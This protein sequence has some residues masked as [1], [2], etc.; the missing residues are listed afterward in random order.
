MKMKRLFSML[1]STAVATSVLPT[2]AFAAQEITVVDTQ[3]AET[4]ATKSGACGD[5]LI[6]VLDDNGNLIIS[7]SGDM[8]DSYTYWFDYND[9]NVWTDYKNSIKT[10]KI[11][12]GVTSIG[13]SSFQFCK[14]LTSISIPSS[15]TSIGKDRY[16]PFISCSSLAN[17][18]VDSNNANYSSQDGVLFDKDKTTLIKCP[19]G[20]RRTAYTIPNS[21]T[22]LR[23]NAFVGCTRLTTVSIPNSVTYIGNSAFQTCSNLVSVSIPSSVT[24][25]GD[26]AFYEC[27]NLTDVFYSGTENEWKKVTIY[28]YNDELINATVHYHTHSYDRGAITTAATCTKAG[29]KTFTCSEC[30]E[31]KRESIPAIGHTKVID[32]AVKA[33]YANT[34]LT[35]GSHCSVC[36]E[37][38]AA[39]QL[40]AKKTVSAVTLSSVANAAGKKMKVKWSKNSK[41][42]GYQI[43]YAASSKFTNTKTV[44]ITAK[45]TTSKT[46][47]KL[48]KNKKYYVRVRAYK[49]ETG[50][51]YYS[52]WSAKK[53]VTI[54]K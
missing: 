9:D 44:E 31:I 4:V 8:Y 51:K 25:I 53:S 18:N 35:E 12:D 47:T 50:K 40:I 5:S 21:V 42:T 36:N 20:N 43:Q 22:T 19:A 34:G 29:V 48:T 33:T 6:W 28:P 16:D 54:K 3:E 13:T 2:A 15:V 10:V 37:I 52:A 7:G 17:I 45:N 30:G 24:K 38:L 26:F 32:A 1:V 14:N 46:I 41:A 23:Y 27:K 11:E 49:T 39:Q